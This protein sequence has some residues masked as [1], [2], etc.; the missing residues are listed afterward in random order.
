MTDDDNSIVL[1]VAAQT[2]VPGLA[3]A[4]VKNLDEGKTVYARAYGVQALYQMSKAVAMANVYLD[5]E[6]HIYSLIHTQVLNAP[7]Q[8]SIREFTFLLVKQSTLQA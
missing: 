2:R 3:G 5:G 4:M 1:K 8:D 6:D 7:N